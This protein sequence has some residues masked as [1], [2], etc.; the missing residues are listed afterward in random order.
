MGDGVSSN[1][2]KMSSSA[3]G[4][5]VVSCSFGAAVAAAWTAGCWPV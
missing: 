2:A 1:L 3:F 4:S 5:V